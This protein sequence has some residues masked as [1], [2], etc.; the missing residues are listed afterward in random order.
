MQRREFLAAS[1]IALGVPSSDRWAGGP[2]RS[3]GSIPIVI[4][5]FDG[6]GFRVVIHD[7]RWQVAAYEHCVEIKGFAG[8]KYDVG[9]METH[10]FHAPPCPFP[11]LPGPVGMTHVMWYRGDDFMEAV[12]SFYRRSSSQLGHLRP[13]GRVDRAGGSGGV[14]FEVSLLAQ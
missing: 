7:P 11:N 2:I 8:G 13:V 9:D 12:G 5:L 1:L 3:G 14:G 6:S 10:D 4:R